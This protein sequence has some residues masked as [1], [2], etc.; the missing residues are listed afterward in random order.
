MDIMLSDLKTQNVILRAELLESF[1]RVLNSGKY[2][3]GEE[4]EKFESYLCTFT[5]NKFAVACSSGTSALEV[6]LRAVGVKAGDEVIIP[7]MTFIATI[8]AVI[9]VGAT[10]VLVDVDRDT[11][12]MD[13]N[14]VEST[15][16]KRT[17]AILPVHL[18]GRMVRMKTLREVIGNNKIKII[19][20]A[21]QS[22]GAYDQDINYPG[23]VLS[24]A[25]CFSFY[26]GKNLGALGEAGA[27]T[28]NNEEY[29]ISAQKI[30][31]WGGR[32]Q[33]QHE[34]Y[35]GNERMDELQAAFL[36]VKLPHLNGYIAKRKEIAK[37]YDDFFDELGIVRP[38]TESGHTYHI[39]AI[40]FDGRDVLS[41]YLKK[42]KIQV[43]I[44]YPNSLNRLE[45]YSS[46]NFAKQQFPIA[47]HLAQH[48]LSIPIHENLTD[49]N[50]NAIRNK[51]KKF[52]KQ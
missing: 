47:E 41:E 20:D 49:I 22:I 23:S 45:V 13:L 32:V 34:V 48:F 52:I 39:Y 15:L 25:A 6:A 17:K 36:S 10:P 18:H 24:D 29:A 28:F 11:W 27:V 16:S 19:E 8:K 14:Q 42:N 44:H 3:S 35:G 1:N 12:T 38:K 46:Y 2:V 5:K 9:A 30:R 31:N 50:I 51:I 33:Y 7:A 26:P 43:G 21:A 37:V 4:V 40:L